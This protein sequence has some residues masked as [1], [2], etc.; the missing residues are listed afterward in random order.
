[1]QLNFKNIA[2]LVFCS[3]I[4]KWLKFPVDGSND[5]CSP[6]FKNCDDNVLEFLK[7]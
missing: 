7:I 5:K 1:M 2:S 3:H 6:H 4:K